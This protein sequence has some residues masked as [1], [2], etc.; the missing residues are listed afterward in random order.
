MRYSRFHHRTANDGGHRKLSLLNGAASCTIPGGVPK[1][2]CKYDLDG[3]IHALQLE[4]I[5]V[6]P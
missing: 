2:M 4:D 3:N 6:G 1:D 5:P